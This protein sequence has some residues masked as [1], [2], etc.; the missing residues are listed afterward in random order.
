VA[1]TYPVILGAL[2]GEF[3]KLTLGGASADEEPYR[4]VDTKV[5]L[6]VGGFAGSARASLFSGELRGLLNDLRSMQSSL[7]GKVDFR[8][9]EG[10]LDFKAAITE[11]GHVN[12]EGHLQDKAGYGNDLKFFLDLDQTFLPPAIAGLE[13]FLGSLE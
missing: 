4:G 7:S 1:K 11:T 2:D 3:L 8:T 5:D 12:I 13:A 9:L 6:K 10:Q